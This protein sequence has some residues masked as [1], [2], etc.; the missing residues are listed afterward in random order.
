MFL[1]NVQQTEPAGSFLFAKDFN[2]ISGA[3]IMAWTTVKSKVKEC[4]V[5]HGLE[6]FA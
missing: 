3:G 4:K 1:V 5:R 2:R 6:F